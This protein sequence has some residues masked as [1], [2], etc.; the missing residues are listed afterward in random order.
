MLQWPQRCASSSPPPAAVAP[1]SHG[2]CLAQHLVPKAGGQAVGG[3][4]IHLH[5]QQLLQ[6]IPDRAN[7]ISV[8]CAVGSTNR[9]RSL[10]VVSSPC[11]AEPNTPTLL[12]RWRSAISRI[13][14]RW[15]ERASEGRIDSSNV[16]I[17]VRYGLVF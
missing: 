1:G 8:V 17:C 9:S 3:E 10:S 16:G 13:C 11:S 4:H 2:H 15:R 5:A 12:T 7:V 6:F 14:E